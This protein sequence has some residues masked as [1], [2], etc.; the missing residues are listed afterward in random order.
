MD[1]IRLQR[2]KK[3]ATEDKQETAPLFTTERTKPENSAVVDQLQK[4]L[5]AVTMKAGEQ[6]DAITAMLKQAVT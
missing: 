2:D 3:E 5:S 4:I 6:L 1:N